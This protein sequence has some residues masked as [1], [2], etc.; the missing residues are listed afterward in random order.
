MEIE[1]LQGKVILMQ[2]EV[3]TEV[4]NIYKGAAA[5]DNQMTKYESVIMQLQ[6]DLVAKTSRLE[7]AITGAYA[8]TQA[9]NSAS[10][11]GDGNRRRVPLDENN[12]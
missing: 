2:A 12:K 4:S 8:A 10:T 6:T 9:T 1:P 5:H 7:G 3:Q 11:S